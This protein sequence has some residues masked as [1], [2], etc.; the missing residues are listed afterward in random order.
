MSFSLEK[1]AFWEKPSGKNKKTS[2]KKTKKDSGKLLGKV[3]SELSSKE[4][5]QR[6]DEPFL[7]KAPGK[8]GNE[9]HK[10]NI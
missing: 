9:L 10:K 3:S 2:E 5:L 6:N 7:E 1:E 8:N 4:S